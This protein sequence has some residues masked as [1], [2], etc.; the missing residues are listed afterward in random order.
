MSQFDS[1]IDT[2][3][4]RIS[5]LEE[6]KRAFQAQ[7]AGKPA[8]LRVL[9]QFILN[10]KKKVEMN[11]YSKRVPIDARVSDQEKVLMLEPMYSMFK[12]IFERLEQLEAKKE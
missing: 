5:E 1:E 8:S 7:T 2:L 6:Q 4:K 12:T 11:M 9:E 10:K 3:K